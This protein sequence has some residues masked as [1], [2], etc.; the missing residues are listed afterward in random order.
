MSSVPR[1]R[2][3]RGGSA[4][5]HRCWRSSAPRVGKLNSAYR[6]TVFDLPRWRW[7]RICVSW[8]LARRRSAWRISS[9]GWMSAASALTPSSSGT[10]ARTPTTTPTVGGTSP[11][12]RAVLLAF[13]ALV[14]DPAGT[15]FVAIRYA[16]DV[17]NKE[18]LRHVRRVLALPVTFIAH[19]FKSEYFALRSLRLPWPRMFF[20]TWTASR[21]LT[22]GLHHAR[23][24][25]PQPKDD[26]A[27]EH[28]ERTARGRRRAATD[29]TTVAER[30]DVVPPFRGNKREM[31][32]RFLSMPENEPM[33][34]EDADYVTSDAF[35]TLA[36]HAPLRL[37]L[38]EHGLDHHYDHIELTA[39]LVLADTEW[40][41]ITI[42]RAKIA[43][44]FD[45]SA[46]AVL[47]YETRLATFGFRTAAG[48]SASGEHATRVVVRS[49]TERVKV[50]GKLRTAS[51]GSVLELFRSRSS[52]RGFSFGKDYLKQHRA[53]HEAIELLYLHSKYSSVVKD[54]LFRGQFIG[55][56]GRV[57][58]WIN[59]LGSDT[60]R[61]TMRQP[62]LFGLGKVLRP[63]VA[64][65]GPEFGVAEVDIAAEEPLVAAVVF[66]DRQLLDDCNSGDVYLRMVR[67]LCG[68][69][70]PPDVETWPDERL[71]RG[72][73]H[74]RDRMKVLLLAV[75]Y[76]ISDEG[77][78]AQALTSVTEAREL[79]RLFFQRY[80]AVATGI[81]LMKRRL[82]ERGHAEAVT[83]IKRFRPGVGALSGW[84]ERWSVNF[85]IQGA[86]ACALKLALPRVH[87][88][89]RRHRG[90]LLLAPF[91]ALVFQ[92]PLEKQDAVVRGVRRIFLQALRD[93]FPGA[94]PRADVNVGDVTC[95]NKSGRGDSIERFAENPEFKP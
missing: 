21:L 29:L 46:A 62:N 73:R 90:R 80:P 20:C 18:V 56:D 68:S 45:A 70:L 78:A 82:C 66:S 60:G 16:I 41:G 23:Y 30:Y 86:S 49:F 8:P 38:I 13:V 26:I 75:L 19:H 17:R 50:L 9:P 87:A 37:A 77:L 79:R 53:A 15:G 88:F 69:G 32:K 33:T 3:D 48:V 81:E 84:E 54:K 72:Y 31:Q 43:M 2:L 40:H 91:D 39:S 92:F 93:L 85:P 1:D 47:R 63:I 58:A 10:R 35:V 51:G 27:E 42:N 89:L 34:R 4:W 22:L 57:H 7:R 71:A 74:L 61:P 65:D 25:D 5:T 24:V 12:L 14:P 67:W 52:A 44:A 55:S 94:H 83:G 95:W 28:A 59:P 6:R 76:G 36:L 11:Q 64:P